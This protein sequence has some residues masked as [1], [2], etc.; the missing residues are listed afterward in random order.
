MIQAH[1]MFIENYKYNMKVLGVGTQ[2][3]NS[4]NEKHNSLKLKIMKEFKFVYAEPCYQ[5][6]E[7]ALMQ[8]NNNNNNI[9]IPSGFFSISISNYFKN[10]DRI[11]YDRL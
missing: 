2:F 3:V 8:V 1:N 9:F 6:Y 5:K 11:K 7:N 4:L 10:N